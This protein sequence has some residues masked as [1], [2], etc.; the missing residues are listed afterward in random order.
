[1][2]P[3]FERSTRGLFRC[4]V[5]ALFVDLFVGFIAFVW[6]ISFLLIASLSHASL[7]MP[8]SSPPTL[9]LPPSPSPQ[10]SNPAPN[11]VIPPTLSKSPKNIPLSS[12][13]LSAIIFPS[14]L[15]TP[16]HPPASTNFTL[17][18]IHRHHLPFEPPLAKV[19]SSHSPSPFP[20]HP[21]I[22]PTHPHK[23]ST[24]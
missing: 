22:S 13:F 15:C 23:P 4:F 3:F 10:L 20:L 8:H 24:S 19:L 1:L 12:K 16:Y 5:M 17:H 2:V 21:P 14:C 7:P 11:S 6:D 9:P 18:A